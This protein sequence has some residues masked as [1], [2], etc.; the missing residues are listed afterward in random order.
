MELERRERQARAFEARH[1]QQLEEK[2]RLQL[3][4]ELLRKGLAQETFLV[5]TLQQ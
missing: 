1:Q 2:N 3:E 4:M 5:S